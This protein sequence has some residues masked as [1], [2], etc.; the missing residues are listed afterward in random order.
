M[1]KNYNPKSFGGWET[2]KQTNPIELKKK[3][4]YNDISITCKNK[5]FGF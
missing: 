1:I 2:K 3:N 5:Y 4:I